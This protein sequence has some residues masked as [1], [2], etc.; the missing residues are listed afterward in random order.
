[1]TAAIQHI[2]DQ[3]TGMTDLFYICL[4]VTQ[5]YKA[6]GWGALPT[7]LA[8]RCDYAFKNTPAME[9]KSL[10]GGTNTMGGR[11][12]VITQGE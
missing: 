9:I 8:T 2:S 3:V 10:G 6:K 5:T 7:E 4:D 11:G 1:V 12:G